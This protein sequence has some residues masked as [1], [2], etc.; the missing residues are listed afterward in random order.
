[1]RPSVVIPIL[2]AVFLILFW[3][4][5]AWALNAVVNAL[6]TALQLFP[7]AKTPIAQWGDQAAQVFNWAS[8]VLTTPEGLTAVALITAVSLFIYYANRR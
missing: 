8:S 1:V 4:P 6:S 2:F 3:G 5:L 7:R